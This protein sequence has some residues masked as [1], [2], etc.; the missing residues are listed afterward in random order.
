M[1]AL[2]Q[3]YLKKCHIMDKTTQPDGYGGLVHAWKRGAPIDCA[4][5]LD[6]STEAQI[7]YQSGVVE[8]YSCVTPSSILL[9]AG[10]VVEDEST[11]KQYEITSNSVPMAPL[12]GS[13]IHLAKANAKAISLRKAGA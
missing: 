12:P 11:G 7:A 1:E 10:M 13:D 9:D 8:L 6:S 2:W 3:K 5:T 4:F